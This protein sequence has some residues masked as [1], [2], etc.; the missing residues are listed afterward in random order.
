MHKWN[1]KLFLRIAIQILLSNCMVGGNV[2]TFWACKFTY[3]D[4]FRPDWN[5][6]NVWHWC[7]FVCVESLVASC[8]SPEFGKPRF[9]SKFFR[10]QLGIENGS[11]R[12]R[13]RP[14]DRLNIKDPWNIGLF[15][16]HQMRF[17]YTKLVHSCLLY[18]VNY[19]PGTTVLK[20]F[21]QN[22]DGTFFNIMKWQKFY[23]K[24]TWYR[25]LP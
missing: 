24:A 20:E 22:A 9:L 8:R 11:I 15:F 14:E 18:Q 6:R 17:L 19:P 1:W 4:Y 25:Y 16:L 21:V 3:I 2:L 10:V 23:I 7:V 5:Y 12:G 13:F